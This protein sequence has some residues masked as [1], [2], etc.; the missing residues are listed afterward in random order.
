MF[1]DSFE[2][3]LANCYLLTEQNEEMRR[4]LPFLPSWAW[5]GAC[6]L[7]IRRR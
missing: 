1:N 2:V 7:W 5:K 3:L 6:S 4:A